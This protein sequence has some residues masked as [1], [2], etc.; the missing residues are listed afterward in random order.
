MNIN[1]LF[2]RLNMTVIYYSIGLTREC[3][4][5]IEKFLSLDG[6]SVLMRAMQTNIEKVKIKSAFMLSAVC[7]DNDKIKGK[8][9]WQTVLY[10]SI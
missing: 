1:K 10:H 5:A 2:Y 4:E 8:I 7:N 9:K 6:F 3:E